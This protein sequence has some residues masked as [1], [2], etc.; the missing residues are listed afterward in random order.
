MSNPESFIEEVTEEVQRDKLFGLMRRY[1]WIAIVA[2]FLAVGGV[3]Y[4]TWRQDQAAA[5]AQALGDSLLSALEIEEDDER[6]AALAALEPGPQA[7]PVVALLQAAERQASDDP[8]AAAAA[9]RVVAEDE[10]APELYRDLAALKL[11][12]QP[13]ETVTA[14]ERAAILER[15]AVPG[16]PFRHLAVEQQVYA[17]VA[18]G[19]LE[20][21]RSAAESLL[22]ETGITPGVKDRLDNL[23][24][25]LG[26]RP[27]SE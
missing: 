17:L 3:A 9:L 5:K 18:S 7:A 8:D 23:I 2:I 16:A 6:A 24:I 22:E 11:A 25:S 14:E 13:S 1:G 12:M 4:T 19:D 27:S 26:V 21:A 20:G 10:S 15:L